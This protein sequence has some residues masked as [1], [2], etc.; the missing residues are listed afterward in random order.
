MSCSPLV[1]VIKFFPFEHML[2]DNGQNSFKGSL[3]YSEQAISISLYNGRTLQEER[4]FL[5]GCSCCRVHQQDIQWWS[6]QATCLEHS[7]SATSHPQCGWGI[8][9]PQS[10][11]QRPWA[12][13]AS[14]SEWHPTPSV[15]THLCVPPPGKLHFP[16]TRPLRVVSYFPSNWKSE[17]L[18]HPDTAA[19]LPQW[20][21]SPSLGKGFP[22][23]DLSSSLYS[24]SALEDSRLFFTSWR[25]CFVIAS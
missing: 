13:Q 22:S 6:V 15:S 10:S 14:H 20:N 9:Y 5:A 23:P 3:R 7:P 18:C 11:L 25:H 2:C 1:P 19:H 17:L 21:L 24:P 16:C 4:V 12:F 8:T